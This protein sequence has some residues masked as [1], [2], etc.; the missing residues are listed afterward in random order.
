MGGLGFSHRC[1]CGF[2]WAW[3]PVPDLGLSLCVNVNEYS[4]PL[5]S[6]EAWGLALVDPPFFPWV[7][8]LS[9]FRNDPCHEDSTDGGG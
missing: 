7:W 5:G 4:S 1:S 9:G 2:R 6:R 8:V 3:F